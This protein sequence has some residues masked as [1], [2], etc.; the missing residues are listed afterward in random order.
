MPER[1]PSRQDRLVLIPRILKTINKLHFLESTSLKSAFVWDDFSV[2]YSK[3]QLP[4]EKNGSLDYVHDF[5]KEQK[6][7]LDEIDLSAPS[8]QDIFNNPNGEEPPHVQLDDISKVFQFGEVLGQGKFGDVHEA[9]LQCRNRDK[10][11]HPREFAIKRMRKP[12][13]GEQPK[14]TV[15]DFVMEQRHLR[16]CKHHHVIEFLASFTDERDFGLITSPVADSTLKGILSEYTE[17]N[18]I[19]DDRATRNALMNA[20]GCLLE[21][22]SYLHDELKIRHRD[23]KPGNILLHNYRVR[24][25]DFGSAYDHEPPDQ[26]ESTEASRP[27]G[28]RRYK[29]PEV[30]PDHEFSVP[31]RHNNTVDMFSLGCIFLEMH[32]VLSEQTLNKM[33]KFITQGGT[34]EFGGSWIYASS[35]KWIDPWLA[36]IGDPHGRGDGP[37]ALIKSMVRLEFYRTRHLVLT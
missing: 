15:A 29:A 14:T 19:I 11:G 24:I 3:A 1:R 26:N 32:T 35:L 7:I 34:S 16:K 5:L 2:P 6:D 21:A 30:L 33:A 37:P 28:T 10:G 17:E 4:E 12:T 13:V 23:L 27:P 20:F 36:E 9:K 18:N 25:C 31:Q 8:V 22:V